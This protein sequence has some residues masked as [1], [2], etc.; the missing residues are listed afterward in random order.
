MSDKPETVTVE[1]TPDLDSILSNAIDAAEAPPAVEPAVAPE[2]PAATALQRDEK[3]RF[4]K[5]APSEEIQPEAAPVEATAEAAVPSAEIAPKP[6]PDPV[7][8]GHF[9]GWTSEQRAKYEALPQEARDVVLALKRDTDAHYTR[10]LTEAADYRKQVD[11]IVK[12]VSEIAPIFASQG[13]NPIQGMQGYANIERTLTYGNYDEKVGLI[14][15]ICQRYGVPFARP[16]SDDPF[17]PV[18]PGSETYRALHDQKAV[19]ARIEADRA[20]LQRQYETLQQQVYQ[21]QISAFETATNPDGSPKHPH[22]TVV[23]PH[24]GALLQSGQAQSLEE[25]YNLAIAPFKDALAA[26]EIEAKRQAETLQQQAI[27]KAKRAAPV[28]ASPTS[29]V[30]KASPGKSLDDVLSSV[31]D[32]AGIV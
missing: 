22:F 32:S 17:N 5:A 18:S 8:E 27:E 28:K 3:G 2:A 10:K 25:A 14:E 24:M 1:E 30:G 20:N 15:K 6:E 31:L 13:M 9:R 16:E 23:K 11:P 26:K 19:Q 7:S 29:P 21:S 4:A 12:A